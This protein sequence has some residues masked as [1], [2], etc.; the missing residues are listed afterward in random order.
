MKRLLLIALLAGGFFAYQWY[1]VPDK[2]L[3][4]WHTY[5]TLYQD[6]HGN[7]LR[8]TLSDDE[9]YRLWIPYEE[10]SKHVIDATILYE[11]RYFHAHPGVNFPALWRAFVATYITHER[12]VGFFRRSRSISG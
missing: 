12:R 2:A 7:M 1:Q 11:D 3:L 9:K 6:R 5:S 8:L 4:A 10:I